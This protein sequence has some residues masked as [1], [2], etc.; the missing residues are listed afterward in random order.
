M[1]ARVLSTTASAVALSLVAASTLA[2]TLPAGTTVQASRET[3]GPLEDDFY[4]SLGGFGFASDTTVTVNGTT[5]QGTPV[6]WEDD[7]GFGDKD[8]FRI[9]GFWRF[10]DRHKVRFMW[11]SNDRERST[12]IDREI[13]FDGQVFPINSTVS[14]SLEIDV[15][16]L[17]YE[18][19]FW[20]REDFEIA[21]TIGAHYAKV[22]LTLSSTG[23][24]TGSR[25]GDA[26]LDA[27][28]P[29]IGLRGVWS[30]GHNVFIDAHAQFF[31][32]E[33]DGVDGS[34]QDYK[35]GISWQPKRWFGIGAGYNY[36]VTDVD[37]DRTAFNGSM[38][39]DYRGPMVFV[40]ASF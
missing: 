30:L 22:G 4:V 38:E 7:L 37:V 40:S 26:D 31:A 29:V 14:S 36:F 24:I 10:A 34:L 18:Y 28:L 19:A 2:Q 25:S 21:G 20:K 27:P 35:L 1:P 32:L 11:F 8:S 23:T 6:D 17:A 15:Y 33:F 3:W 13:I 9:D 5:L 39:W 12:R 16:E